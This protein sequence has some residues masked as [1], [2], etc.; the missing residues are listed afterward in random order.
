MMEAKTIEV[1]DAMTFIPVLAVNLKPGNLDDRYLLAR[2]GYSPHP[3]EQARY[4]ILIRIE[5]KMAA[6]YDP[7]DWSSDTRTM[8]TAHQYLIDHWDDVESGDIVDVQFI[9]GETDEPKVSEAL[10]GVW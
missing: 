8:P 4:V 5:G 1:R 7:I 10:K 3:E 9:L 2:A 6:H